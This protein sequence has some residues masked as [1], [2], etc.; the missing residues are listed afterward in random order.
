MLLL[1][2]DDELDQLLKLDSYRF[3]NCLVWMSL[4]SASSHIATFYSKYVKKKSEIYLEI[5]TY[6]WSSL[7]NLRQNNPVDTSLQ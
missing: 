4:Y 7:V 5:Q 3:S 1:L 2:D 6:G